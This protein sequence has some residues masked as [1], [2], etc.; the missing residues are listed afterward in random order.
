M[1]S[2][3]A[4]LIGFGLFLSIAC[5]RASVPEFQ[6]TATVKDIMD[7]IVDPNADFV[8]DSVEVVV[9]IEGTEEKAPKTDDD[10][11]ALRR[12]A[13][14]LLEASNLLLVPGRQIAKPGEKAEDARVDLEPEEIEARIKQD[15]A[16]WAVGAHGLHDA[17]LESLKAI[18]ARDVKGLLNAG[19][20]LDQSCETCHRKYWYRVP[21]PTGAPPD[22]SER[23]KTGY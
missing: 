14:A 1:R 20:A 15:P 8:W 16:A 2:V 7:S 9:T 11:K 6:P 23:P 12:H 13:I 19:D 5:T 18:E 21:P 17:T 10:W 3:L 4:A 22:A